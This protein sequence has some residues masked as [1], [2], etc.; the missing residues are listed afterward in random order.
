MINLVKGQTA[1]SLLWFSALQSVLFKSIKEAPLPP[2]AIS[3][4]DTSTY[5]HLLGKNTSQSSLCTGDEY[6][7]YIPDYL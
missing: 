7:G 6:C 2:S 4:S 3:P 5:Y 1:Y